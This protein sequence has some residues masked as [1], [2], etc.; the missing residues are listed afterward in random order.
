ML[1]RE[2]KDFGEKVTEL[3]T[4]ADRERERRKQLEESHRGIVAEITK[5]SL[6]MEAGLRDAEVKVEVLRREKKSLTEELD[7]TSR[8]LDGEFFYPYQFQISNTNFK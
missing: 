7:K 2:R 8:A 6:E 1:L 4:V 5:K 3:E